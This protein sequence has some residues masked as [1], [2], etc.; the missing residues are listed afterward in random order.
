MLSKGISNT[1]IQDLGV[2]FDAGGLLAHIHFRRHKQHTI[3]HTWA[4]TV[5]PYERKYE[6]SYIAIS[7]MRDPLMQLDGVDHPSSSAYDGRVGHT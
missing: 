4:C 1:A 7:T 2:G 6:I 5:Y 3:D